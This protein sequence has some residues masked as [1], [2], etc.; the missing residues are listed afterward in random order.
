MVGPDGPNGE[1]AAASP[2]QVN[3]P[4]RTRSPHGGRSTPIRCV[5]SD[6]T[7]RQWGPYVDYGLVRLTEP[8]V[9]VAWVLLEEP[10]GRHWGYQLSRRAGVRSGVLYPILQRMLEE[11]WLLDGWEDPERAATRPRRRYYELTDDGRQALGGLLA[12]ARDDSRFTP[13]FDWVD[14]VGFT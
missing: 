11:G 6:G 3:V 14:R 1:T 7:L 10:F 13:L 4:R 8:L 2:L 12:R 9:R 5:P